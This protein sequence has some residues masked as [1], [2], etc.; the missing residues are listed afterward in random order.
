MDAFVKLKSPFYTPVQYWYDP[1]THTIWKVR[2]G[3]LPWR[4]EVPT[5]EETQALVQLNRL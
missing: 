3:C 1:V 2:L 4:L 5:P